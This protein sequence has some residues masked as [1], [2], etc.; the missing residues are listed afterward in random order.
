MKG[1]SSDMEKGFFDEYIGAALEYDIF[2]GGDP[3]RP[4]SDRYTSQSAENSDKSAIAEKEAIDT[5]NNQTQD[6][7]SQVNNMPDNDNETENIN[8]SQQMDTSSDVDTGMDENSEDNEN[9]D[10]IGNDI[11][12]NED[13]TETSNLSDQNSDLDK[14]RKDVLFEVTSSLHCAISN[15]IEMLEKIN[16]PINEDANKVYYDVINQLRHCKNTLYNIATKEL[17][18]GDYVDILRRVIALSKVYELS[19]ESIKMIYPK[20]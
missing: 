20:K 9:N 13:S 15:N 16:P 3:N 1:W 14:K 11:E 10:D 17:Q 4:K 8:D 2:A 5:G 12:N 19:I 7:Q 18:N 6:E